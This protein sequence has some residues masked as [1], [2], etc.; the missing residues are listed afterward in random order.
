MSPITV[1]VA[2]VLVHL[3]LGL[4]NL[5]APGLPLGDVTI[6]YRFWT[7]QA[8][9]AQFW[10]GIDSVWV[11]PIVAWVPMLIAGAFGSALYASTWLSMVLV[12]DAI[13]FG[14]L[15]GWGRSR[16]R[17]GVAW[18]WI[19]FLLLLG[20]IASG[21]IDSISVPLAMIGLIVIARRPRVA[22]LLLTIA[23]WIKVWPA[24]LVFAAVIA[25]RDRWRILAT[26]VITSVGIVGVALALGSGMNV[27]SFITQQTGRGLQPE[28]PVSTFFMWQALA[29]VPGAFVYYDSSILS[30]AVK[31]PGD[32]IAIALMSPLLALVALAIALL[33][34]RAVRRG[35]QPGDLFP[36]LALALTTTFIAVNKVGS[37][38]YIAW[39]AVPI[40]L[41]IA[42]SAAGNG[43]S[44]R[45][46]AILGLAIAGLTQVIYPYFYHWLISLDPLMV[47]AL[48]VRNVLE[49]VLLG[50]AIFAVYQ[51]PD[52]AS[53]DNGDEQE[54]LPSVWPLATSSDLRAESEPAPSSD[55]ADRAQTGARLAVGD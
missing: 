30:Y 31:G 9:Y 49:F 5:Y 11:Y 45:T 52:M 3:I 2:F 34:V 44:F 32:A 36:P 35:A 22:A 33:G 1:W 51:A 28:S 42:T 20:P 7:D 18:W 41:G 21:R 12:L 27:I 4:L 15:T 39:L 19:A 26:A 10:V 54:W 37:P 13:A 38:Q 47:S 16:E 17:L 8:L 53:I 48:T 23:T 50:W 40:V 6:V 43:R 55:V 24:A 25:L 29:R 14:I 46:P